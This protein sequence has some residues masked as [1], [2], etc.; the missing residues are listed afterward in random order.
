MNKLEAGVQKYIAEQGQGDKGQG[1]Q[2]QDE[3]P[4]SG[5]QKKEI[6]DQTLGTSQELVPDPSE[7][8]GPSLSEIIDPFSVEA[9]EPP[10]HD[11]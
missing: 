3:A 8:T 10:T 5:K 4:S 1:D 7:V 6:D 2:D 11:L 9:T